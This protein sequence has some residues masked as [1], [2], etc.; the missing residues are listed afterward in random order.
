[1]LEY[2]NGQ[3]QER[4]VHYDAMKRC[5]C[6]LEIKCGSDLI[7]TDLWSKTRDKLILFRKFITSQDL[8]DNTNFL[9]VSNHMGH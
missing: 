8:S 7:R 2:D 9:A 5:L 1:M 4:Y 3:M 6:M